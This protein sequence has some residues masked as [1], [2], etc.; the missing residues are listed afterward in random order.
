MNLFLFFRLL[1]ILI[2][3]IFNFYK[4]NMKSYVIKIIII[5]LLIFSFAFLTPNIAWAG[6]IDNMSFSNYLTSADGAPEYTNM[7]A[8]LILDDP[9]V[10]GDKIKITFVDYEAAQH[11]QFDLG[12]ITTANVVITCD[13]EGTNGNIDDTAVVV[14][15][16]GGTS[17]DYLTITTGDDCA[18]S[19]MSVELTGNLIRTPYRSGAYHIR[20]DYLDSEGT[21]FLNDTITPY[22]GFLSWF[23]RWDTVGEECPGPGP[24]TVTSNTGDPICNAELDFFDN[25][26]YVGTAGS[27]WTIHGLKIDFT[28]LGG[29]DFLQYVTLG[30]V[31]VSGDSGS[32]EIETNN[33]S[34]SNQTF[35]ECS[36]TICLDFQGSNKNIP[37]GSYITLTINNLTTDN[38]HQVVLPI[39]GTYQLPF[40]IDEIG[41][42]DDN[43]WDLGN[44][45]L[46]SEGTIPVYI[47][48][49]ENA[50]VEITAQIDPALT[51]ELSS[52]TCDFGVFDPTKYNTCGYYTTI[53]TN[54][55]GGYTEYFRQDHK[56]QIIGGHEM[57]DVE[58]YGD[59]LT[60]GTESYGF[61]YLND[62]YDTGECATY[63]G[64]DGVETVWIDPIPSE[65]IDLWTFAEPVSDVVHSYCHGL[66]ISGTTPAGL[67][68]H[69]ITITVTG[70]F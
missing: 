46:L 11:N 4:T 53:S 8:N 27:C 42:E 65:E 23:Y 33:S 70:N 50:D 54:A 12:A 48:S 32:V 61:V 39:A 22:M 66:T 69:M 41:C 49:Q 63:D 18:H 30:D 3:D 36:G 5:I 37:A 20:V 9:W 67:Y 6:F 15:N 59:F 62:P 19:M 34:V 52:N 57:A 13:P 1:N 24:D 17:S 43:P 44:Y 55:A 26:N 28:S 14:T 47:T 60:I 2:T 10:S 56:L 29:N 40:E 51:L 68:Q 64:T 7:T 35:S 21:S 31:N 16:G 38:A 25:D 58:E 45:E